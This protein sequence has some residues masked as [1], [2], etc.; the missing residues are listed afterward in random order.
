MKDQKHIGF[1]TLAAQAK[2]SRPKNNGLKISQ[3]LVVNPI[4]RETID[5]S[6]CTNAVRAADRGNRALLINL[7]SNLIQMDPVLADA[8]DKRIRAVTNFDLK[9]LSDGK[10]IDVMADFIDTPEFEDLLTEIMLTKLLGKT[11]IELSFKDGFKLFSVPRG[12]LQTQ[13]KQILRSLSDQDGIPYENDPFLLNLGKDD[14]LGTL[15]RVA[16]YAIFKRNGGSDYAQFCELFGIPILAGLYD[17]EDEGGREEME[18][19]FRKRGAGGSVTMSNK[20]DIKVIGEAGSKGT[21]VHEGF[22]KWCD[23][24]ILIGIVSQTMTTMNGSSLAQGKVHLEVENDLN[25]ADRRY[26]QRVLNRMLLPLLEK[27]GY[28]VQNGWFNFIEKEKATPQEKLQIA[29]SVDS[30]T[31]EGV[32]DDYFYEE[33]GLPKGKKATERAAAVKKGLDDIT[34]EEE[35]SLEKDEKEKPKAQKLTARELSFFEKLKDFFAHAP[36]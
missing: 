22:L 19:A 31:A 36:R 35:E 11:V 20:G 32:D 14:D 30:A 27:R 2:E 8:I 33:F 6:T 17:P 3:V 16:P 34:D 1:Q 23:Q 28:P 5:I 26:V 15:M 10:E 21:P 18:N 9:F 12:H 25:K 4:R 24:Q 7:F 29:L 13:K